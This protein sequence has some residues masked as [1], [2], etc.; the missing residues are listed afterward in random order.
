MSFSRFIF[1]RRDL[2]NPGHLI[3]KIP[4]KTVLPPPEGVPAALGPHGNTDGYAKFMSILLRS[5]FSYSLLFLFC[6][7]LSL[8]DKCSMKSKP[9]TADMPCRWG[10]T[11]W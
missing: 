8:V 10:N 5:R 6:F 2:R 3:V 4:M 7:M 1:V 9:S 11:S